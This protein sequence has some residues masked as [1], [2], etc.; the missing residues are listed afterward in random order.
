[1]LLAMAFDHFIAICKPLRYTTILTDSRIVK[2]W[3]AILVKGV[4]ILLPL[5]LFL[6]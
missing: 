5:V 1:M 3:F 2:M 4:V 6:K